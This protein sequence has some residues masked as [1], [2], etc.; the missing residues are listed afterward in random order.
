[1]HVE[2]LTGNV[3]RLVEFLD[4]YDVLNEPEG[5]FEVSF[6]SG[7]HPYANGGEVAEFPSRSEVEGLAI[8]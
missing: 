6:S 7:W 3:V 5:S 4:R 1:M 8:E 2:H